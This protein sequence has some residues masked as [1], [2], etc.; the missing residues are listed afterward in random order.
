MGVPWWQRRRGG[1]RRI[2]SVRGLAVGLG[3]RCVRWREGRRRRKQRTGTGQTGAD[4]DE[5]RFGR[6]TMTK[7]KKKSKEK[8]KKRRWDEA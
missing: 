5:N 4:E 6:E 8:K 2:S 7:T 3:G 1:A